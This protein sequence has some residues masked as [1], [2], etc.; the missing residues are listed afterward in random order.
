LAAQP[1]QEAS[2]VSLVVPASTFMA[3]PP[4]FGSAGL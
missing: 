4:S 1:P 2:S 3:T